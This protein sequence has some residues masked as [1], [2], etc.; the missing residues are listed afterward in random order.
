MLIDNRIDKEFFYA[1]N[2]EQCGNYNYPVEPSK[3]MGKNK[4]NEKM[5]DKMSRS[6]K[7]IYISL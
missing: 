3:K 6:V 5:R 2:D 1:N 4:T 7:A